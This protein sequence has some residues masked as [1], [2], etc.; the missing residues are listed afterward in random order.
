MAP[1]MSLVSQGRFPGFQA[2]DMSQDVK[3]TRPWSSYSLGQQ[4]QTQIYRRPTKESP[5]IITDS[6]V[7]AC[8]SVWGWPVAVDYA[9][10][11]QF[12]QTSPF[13]HDGCFAVKRKAAMIV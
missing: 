11:C 3:T 10:F 12:L 6:V 2:E 5:H 1:P 7:P 8:G 4:Q 9:M 13:A